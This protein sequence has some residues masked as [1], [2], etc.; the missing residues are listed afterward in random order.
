MII[1]ARDKTHEKDAEG[2]LEES[3]SSFRFL[4]DAMNE[5]A[6]FQ[7]AQ[8]RIL[9]ANHKAGSLLGVSVT[10][11]AGKNFPDLGLTAV[12]EDGSDFPLEE[13]P[14]L[15][16]VRTSRPVEA[17]VMGVFQPAHNLRRWIRISAFPR[18][19]AG[20]TTPYEVFT[21]FVE[22]ASPHPGQVPVAKKEKRS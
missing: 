12:R 2:A 6:M 22:I 5:G 1:V 15:M 20:A 18:L 3:E 11:M 7:D 16:A 21:T 19:R 4:F 13:H 8:G 14:S 9:R 10:K 17:V